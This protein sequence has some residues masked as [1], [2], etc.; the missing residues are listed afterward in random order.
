MTNFK[1]YL[2]NCVEIFQLS[3][4][5]TWTK[6][7][8]LDGGK[9]ILVHVWGAGG[10]GNDYYSGS[11]SNWRGGGGGGLAVKLIT[12]ASLGGTETITVGAYDYSS[13]LPG[14]TSSF[15][16]HCS[17][18][19]GNGGVCSTSNAG[20]NGGTNGIANYGVGGLGIGG[21]INRRGGQGGTGYYSTYDN[22]GGG[23][24][25][26]APAPYGARDGF[27]GGNGSTYAGG[28]G[29]GI[30]GIG[31]SGSYSGGSGGGSMRSGPVS[32]SRS[33]SYTPEPGGNG[34]FGPGSCS[35]TTYVCYVTYGGSAGRNPS[36]AGGDFLLS[37]NEIYL[38]G[39]GG[40]AGQYNDLPSSPR[41]MH[42]GS[43]GGPGGGGGGT[44]KYTTT[45]FY[46]CAGD[47]GLLGG[48]GG[49]SDY[50]SPGKGGNA[51]G[52]GSAGYYMNGD[53]TQPGRGGDGL[54]VIQYARL[55]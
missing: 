38:G 42:N 50:A 10:S 45:G 9:P 28:G 39:G 4:S 47:G 30:G 53:P 6:P 43:P 19:G 25:G 36:R 24:G 14:G 18:T 48:G 41:A 51:G 52:G 40:T 3:G 13:N 2:Y 5:Y 22:A 46:G 32:Y 49:C 55:V 15:G 7:T 21:D 26:S 17:A 1:S 31:R 54:V 27:N 33:S 34:L 8:D 29:G 23:G 35:G 44:G 37:P 16:S 12:P 20:S 11:D